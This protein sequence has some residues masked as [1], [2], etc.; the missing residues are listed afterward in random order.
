M[1][2][3]YMLSQPS[4][5]H[6]T[7]T[8]MY[9]YM[10]CI[11]IHTTHTHTHTTHTHTHTHTQCRTHHLPYTTAHMG[12]ACMH[13]YTLLGTPISTRTSTSLALHVHE[14]TTN[15]Q[16]ESKATTGH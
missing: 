4:T 12:H 3:D 14:L 5:N 10:Y 13:M 16:H 15:V 1:S 8:P 6:H 2:L 11:H 7:H 9:M